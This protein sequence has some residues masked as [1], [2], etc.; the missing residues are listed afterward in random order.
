MAKVYNPRLR[1]KNPLQYLGNESPN[2][3]NILEF[4]RAPTANDY[5]GFDIGDFWVYQATPQELY[6]LTN[7]ENKVSTWLH[8]VTGDVTFGVMGQGTLR[9]TAANV[10]YS[11]ADGVDLDVYM[12]STG[13]TSE[14]GQ[15]ES[16]GATVTITRTATGINLEAAGGTA[17]NTFTMDDANVVVPDGAGNVDVVGGSNI[18][19]TGAVANQMVF[20]LDNDV[21]I[22]GDFNAD[23]GD[24]SGDVT[25]VGDLIVNDITANDATFAGD[26]TVDG[27]LVDAI[28][29][30]FQTGTTYTLVLTDASKEVSLDNAAAIALTIPPNASVAFDIGTQII[31]T[32][33]GAGTVTVGP[34]GGV[35][36]NSASAMLD[37]YEQ[38]SAAAL[39]K[40]DTD[41]WLL[42]GD[43]A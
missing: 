33:T 40:Q 30:N 29:I 9:S 42:V 35:T 24:F 18:T 21:T 13:N 2:P 23:N 11:L 34:G 36:I 12:G 25:I 4:D 37:L 39:I 5:S 32:Q 28:N 17:A 1:G 3:P 15:I 22:T 14:W 26:V 8:I 10:I 43:I 31:I 41:I 20:D 7:K 38:Y 27:N 19:T 16:M 6:V